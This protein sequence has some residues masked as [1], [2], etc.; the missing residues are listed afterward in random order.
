MYDGDWKDN[1]AHGKGSYT[2][3]DGAKYIGDWKDDK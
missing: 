3:A 1:K 2:H